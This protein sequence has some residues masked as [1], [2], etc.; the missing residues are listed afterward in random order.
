MF[1]PASVIL[2]LAVLSARDITEA[3]PMEGEFK[4]RSYRNGSIIPLAK[5]VGKR[6]FVYKG[7]VQLSATTVLDE[8]LFCS[9][10]T[11]LQT[12]PCTDAQIVAS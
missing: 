4:G 12:L 9:Q 7:W 1:S 3:K 6:K 10:D 11:H 8:Y 2:L 5:A